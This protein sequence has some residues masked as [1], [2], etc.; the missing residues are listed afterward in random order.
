M[1]CYTSPLWKSS[2]CK[3]FQRFFL[4]FLFVVH[5]ATPHLQH[6]I[7]ITNTMSR[8]FM[9][10]APMRGS[11]RMRIHEEDEANLRIHAQNNGTDVSTFV[12]K[13][14]I[15]AGVLNPL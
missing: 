11:L 12:R 14:L 3:G 5:K 7:K 15:D 9:R 2:F 6:K 13:V 10:K 8:T 4:L 1:G